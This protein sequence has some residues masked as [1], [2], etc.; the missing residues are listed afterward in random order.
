MYDNIV[1]DIYGTLIDIHT[2]EQRIEL[3][4]N[5]SILLEGYGVSIPE[6]ELRKAYINGCSAQVKR[7]SKKYDY[8]EV[9]VIKVFQGIAKK[10][11][12]TLSRRTAKAIAV[13]MRVLSTEYIKLYDNVKSTLEHLKERG[14]CLYILSNAQKC[15]TRRELKNLGL[16][17][18]FDGIVYS[19]DCGVAKPSA[20]FFNVIIEKYNLNKEHTI[21]VGNDALSDVNGARNAGISC[22]WLKT[23]HTSPDIFPEQPPEYVIEDGRIEELLRIIE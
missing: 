19:S 21:Y 5:L 20:M 23:N 6:E 2:D 18:Y 13:S 10:Y 4:H 14:K 7:R 12:V 11:D 15:F 1:F 17:K 8:P 22:V 3:W 16:L 9:D